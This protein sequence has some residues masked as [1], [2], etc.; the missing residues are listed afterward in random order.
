MVGGSCTGGAH[1]CKAKQGRREDRADVWIPA[2][3]VVRFWSCVHSE[4]KIILVSMAC[5]VSSSSRKGSD[6]RCGRSVLTQ[7]SWT[8]RGHRAGGWMPGARD[9]DIDSWW[10]PIFW[11]RLKLLREAQWANEV[12]LY[13][14]TRTVPIYLSH[15]LP[16]TVPHPNR[17]TPVVGWP[18]VG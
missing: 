6:R 8:E 10:C 5:S 9:S 11:H 2:S 17:I 15:G 13:A 7:S 1:R 18:S 12:T 3:K 16:G 4:K 14:Q